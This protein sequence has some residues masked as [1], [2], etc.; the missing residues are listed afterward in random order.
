M[1]WYEWYLLG[2]TTNGSAG[3]VLEVEKR[4]GLS[5]AESVEPIT[6]VGYSREFSGEQMKKG[7]TEAEILRPGT[8]HGLGR[9][10]LGQ[11]KKERG[12]P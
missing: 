1:Y 3:D 5:L 9:D 12:S 11:W 6:A 7:L 8:E 4:N 2:K 10:S